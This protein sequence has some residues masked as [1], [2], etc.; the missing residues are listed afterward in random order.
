MDLGRETL[1]LLAQSDPDTVQEDEREEEEVEETSEGL[2]T[3]STTM[4]T[5]P[6]TARTSEDKDS[7]DGEDIE[8]G[9]RFRNIEEWNFSSVQTVDEKSVDEVGWVYV[10]LCLYDFMSAGSSEWVDRQDLQ[11]RQGP[12]RG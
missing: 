10:E 1:T 2:T 12:S 7:L 3:T 9:R 5:H 11:K 4:S 8:V 6:L